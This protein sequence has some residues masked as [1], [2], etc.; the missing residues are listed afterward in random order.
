MIT[1]TESSKWCITSGTVVILLV[2]FLPW[3]HPENRFFLVRT[4]AR[5]QPRMLYVHPDL[6]W[7]QRMALFYL[8]IKFVDVVLLWKFLIGKICQCKGRSIEY[9]FLI[10]NTVKCNVNKTPIH[11]KTLSV[12]SFSM[13]VHAKTN[14]SVS[15]ICLRNLFRDMCFTCTPCQLS[16]NEYTDRTLVRSKRCCWWENQMERERTS[17]SLFAPL[18]HNE[19]ISWFKV[20]NS[21]VTTVIN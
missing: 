5:Q 16:Y 19:M 11:K 15:N 10:N 2:V 12:N 7:L 13:M 20:N 6:I 8:L 14:F 9:S 3:K 4:K 21:G 17:L 1:E 18:H